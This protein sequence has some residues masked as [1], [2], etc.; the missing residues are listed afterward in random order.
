MKHTRHAIGFTLVELLVVIGIIAVLVGILL[1]SLNRAQES[2]R[3]VKCASNL[4]QIGTGFIGYASSN[5]GL[6]PRV[7]FKN[8]DGLGIVVSVA[9]RMALNP[10]VPVVA[11]PSG[12]EL[13]TGWNNVPA[14][15]F[16]LVRN[17]LVTPEVFLCPSAQS[18]GAAVADNLGGLDSP[19]K[20]SNFTSLAGLGGQSNLSYSVQ[21]MYPLQ[22]GL[23]EGW[24]WDTATDSDLPIAAD[25]NP[26][27]TDAAANDLQNLKHDTSDITLI[28]KFNSRN[29]RGLRGTKE[30]QNVLYADGHVEFKDSPYCGVD[31]SCPTDAS[32]NTKF[33]DNIF[34]AD[35]DDPT[36]EVNQQIQTANGQGAATLRPKHIFDSIMLPATDS[37]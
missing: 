32:G 4:R 14:S 25:M 2:A 34:T 35:G 15:L 10:F 31:R 37:N 19:L 18:A 9:G 20:R 23:R 12:A 26:G 5:N 17:R 13:D 3:R 33:K 1:P 6:F 8:D 28:R 27:L 24:V 16:L 11:N 29:H 21:V 30:G 22:A 7:Q 36:T